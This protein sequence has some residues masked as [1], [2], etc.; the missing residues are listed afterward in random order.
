L[1]ALILAYKRPELLTNLVNRLLFVENEFLRKNA[2]PFITQVI[3]VHD[4]LRREENTHGI[5][6]HQETRLAC[7]KLADSSKTTRISTL[8]YKENVGLTNHVFRIVK[9]LGVQAQD[10]VFFEEDK[11]PTLESFQFLNRYHKELGEIELLD[12]LP[13]NKHSTNAYEKLGTL[14]TNNGNMVISNKLFHEASELW[15]TGRH[16]EKEFEKNLY[17]YFNSFLKGFALSRAI[18]YY[19]RF[20]AWGLKNKDRPDSLFSYALVL[21]QRVKICPSTPTSEDWSDRDTRGKNVN[22]VSVHSGSVCKSSRIKVWEAEICPDC[23]R[24]GVSK[25]VGLTIRSSISNSFEYRIRGAKGISEI[26]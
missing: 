16:Y 6:H 24:Q 12:T 22:Y 3:I 18:N 11:A 20:F 10:C 21:R 15:Q 1:L 17:I 8:L 14:F 7:K 26:K 25:R 2:R 9:D 5:K 13:L 19:S 4:G 23:E